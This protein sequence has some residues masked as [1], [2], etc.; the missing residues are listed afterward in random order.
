LVNGRL[1]HQPDR[2]GARRRVI[3]TMNTRSLGAMEKHTHETHREH[4]HQNHYPRL[5]IMAV[6]SFIAMFIL[7]YAM[8]DVFANVLS[9][10]NQAYMAG[11]MVSPMIVIELLVMRTMYQ[12]RKLNALLIV[13]SIVA[14]VLCFAAIRQQTLITDVQFVRSMIPHHAGAILM[15]NESAIQD[16]E[17]KKLC[18]E[19][20]ESQTRE[21]AQMKAILQRLDRGN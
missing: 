3:I 2:S 19:I 6:L 14:G 16:P 12:N 1:L 15:C 13:G 7:M 17:I 4:A 21:I 18:D 20:R 9:N 5:A 10:L 11:L 8:V